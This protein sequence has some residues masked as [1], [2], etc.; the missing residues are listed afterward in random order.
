MLH[1]EMS[2][3]VNYF[4]TVFILFSKLI[5]SFLL[6]VKKGIAHNYQFEK[7]TLNCV[8]VLPIKKVEIMALLFNFFLAM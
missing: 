8:G 5:A 4:L 3:F 6:S 7:K 1:C 2:E